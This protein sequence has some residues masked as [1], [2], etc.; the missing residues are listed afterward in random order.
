M[1]R[2]ISHGEEPFYSDTP[3]SLYLFTAMLGLLIGADLW[4]GFVQWI[5]LSDSLPTWSR[6]VFGYRFALLAAILGGARTL[7]GSLDSLFAGRLGADLAVALACIAAI[8]IGEP[9]VAAEVVFIGMIGEVLESFTF[10]RTQKA[11]RKLA[12]IRPRRCWLLKDGEE[13]RIKVNELKVG[14]Q[15]VVKPGARIPADGIVLAGQSSVDL[16]ALTG[17]SL[18][19]EKGPGDEILTG[20]LNQYGALT[21]EAQRV[22]E[23]TVVGRVLKMTGDAL[24]QKGSSERTADRLAKYFLPA[25]LGLALITFLVGLI[26]HAGVFSNT[27]SELK[28]EFWQA[29]RLA[30]Y[31]ALSILVVACPCALILAT[32]AAIIAAL[33]RLAGTGVL[34]KS[35]AALEKLAQVK[36]IAFDKTGTLTEGKL[37][38][39]D[40][41]P[42]SEIDENELLQLAATAEQRSEHVIA[43]LIVE[44]A[45]Q[46]N[47]SLTTIE[48]FQAHPGSG[49][50]AK[51]Q[52]QTITIGTPRLMEQQEIPITDEAKQA[53][54]QLDET[55]QTAL[56]IARDRQILG[57]IGARDR[58]RAEAADILTELR[59]QGINRIALL[60]GD[61]ESAASVVS[62]RLAIEESHAQLLPDQK[63]NWIAQES[64]TESPIVMVGDGINDAPALAQADVGIAIGGAGSDIAAEAGDIVFMGDPLR[65]L[66]L[67]MRLSQETVRIIRQNIIIF[68]FGVNIVGIVVTAW[69]WPLVASPEWYEESPI[70]AVIYHQLGSFL[71]L[72]NAMRLLWFE[73][74][75][76]PRTVAWKQQIGRV[77]EWMERNLDVD[78]WLHGVAHRWKL[79]LSIFGILFVT[80]YALSGITTVAPDEIGI[81]QRFGKVVDEELKPGWYWRL[82]WPMESVTKIN[83]AK[84]RTI[85]VGYRS[86]ENSNQLES[87]GWAEEHG[88]S[89]ELRPAEAL[90]LTGDGNLVEVKVAIHYRVTQ[91]RIYLFEVQQPEELIRS[92]AEAVIREVI[93]GSSF[94]TLLT[95]QRSLVQQSINQA[96]TMRCQS[97][98]KHGIGITIERVTFQEL[99]P[100]QE[101]V[102]AY[103]D[104]TKAMEERN[105][106]IIDAQ[107]T[108]LE[109]SQQ[110]ESRAERE[111]LEAFA[112]QDGIVRR[113][114]AQRIVFN[115]KLTSRNQLPLHK[116]V[117]IL[118]LSLFDENLATTPADKYQAYQRKRESTLTRQKQLVDA[119]LRL[120]SLE[121]SLN[122]S[123]KIIIDAPEP[124]PFYLYALEQVRTL[125]Q[126]PRSRR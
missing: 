92:I 3:L 24:Q 74:K 98:S 79:A 67:L 116:E 126:S 96:L 22:A 26:F 30:T 45:K 91:P 72:L 68:A 39:G 117:S 28:P 104:V 73:R 69:I 5:G 125:L 120:D 12:E 54:T 7:Y 103:H 37:E 81:V 15:V 65:P 43:T 86:R 66:P 55:G 38:L 49:V 77:N 53:L 33:G 106:R 9:L 11:V 87:G 58:V 111:R 100:P 113:A 32:P 112:E 4:P 124:L 57:L 76:S 10:E 40:L 19:I 13:I 29:A 42:L 31:P 75:D 122:G 64:N 118:L 18:P 93:A 105:K 14:D 51:V 21:I 95:D 78:E 50:T 1:H 71:V 119:R 110:A 63:S 52:N 84:I 108:A 80:G 59:N 20:S 62:E 16:S 27:P 56:F 35:G 109:E 17:E 88:K 23:D 2:E 97:I 6:D 94:S 121:K 83:P 101:V 46:R 8:L 48:E 90:M 41:I 114:K 99:H 47:L 34:I 60:T 82:P 123:E 44:E 107:R 102:P 89:I 85:E 115:A 61:R 36:T 25:V 70:V